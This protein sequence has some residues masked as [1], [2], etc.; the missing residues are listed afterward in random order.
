MA[1]PVTERATMAQYTGGVFDAETGL[2][3]GRHDNRMSW[4]AGVDRR[5]MG[6]A[7]RRGWDAGR[8]KRMAAKAATR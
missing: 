4:A 6:D 2:E 8:E 7:Y 5:Q 3:Y 1:L